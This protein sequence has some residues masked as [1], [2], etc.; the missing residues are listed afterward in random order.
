MIS[1]GS[2]RA[3]RDHRSRMTSKRANHGQ[4]NEEVASPHPLQFP[5][6]ARVPIRRLLRPWAVGRAACLT[7]LQFS[8]KVGS[9]SVRAG[10]ES[11]TNRF[12][13]PRFILQ[14]GR[15]S[16]TANRQ[17]YTT[18]HHCSNRIRRILG[19]THSYPLYCYWGKGRMPLRMKAQI[20]LCYRRR[21]TWARRWLW[22]G[23]TGR[24]P[25]TVCRLPKTAE[26]GSY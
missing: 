10:L 8:R 5:P 2:W 24:Q 26:I 13:S 14:A 25:S 3:A 6:I 22:N 16:I 18:L 23:S 9:S 7:L 11:A 4:T 21:L 12:L 20:E 17:S 15:S 19:S 1:S